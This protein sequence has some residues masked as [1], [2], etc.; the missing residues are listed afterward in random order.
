[1]KDAE[2][3]TPLI[4]T[5]LH[6]PSLLVELVALSPRGDF[7]PILRMFQ[8]RPEAVDGTFVLPPSV[9]RV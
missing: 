7:R 6:R 1:M 8:P 5:K 4:L 9:K 2:I 3:T